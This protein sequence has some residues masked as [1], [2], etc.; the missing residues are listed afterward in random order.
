MLDE[1]QS[2]QIQA[3]YDDGTEF[4]QE[5]KKDDSYDQLRA[6]DI[7]EGFYLDGGRRDALESRWTKRWS[8]LSSGG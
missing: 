1:G 3:I 4:L 5:F 7:L 6:K 8:T 2:Q